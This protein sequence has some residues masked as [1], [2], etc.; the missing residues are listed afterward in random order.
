MNMFNSKEIKGVFLIIFVLAMFMILALLRNINITNP[1]RFIDESEIEMNQ[2]DS[3]FP[4][5]KNTFTNHQNYD[6]KYEVQDEVTDLQF[7]PFDPNNIDKQSLKEMGINDNGINNWLKYLAKGGRFKTKEDVAKIY[8]IS[9]QTFEAMK[10]YLIIEN[11]VN[12]D[13]PLPKAQISEKT[14][15]PDSLSTT[16]NNTTV[17]PTKMVDI[18]FASAEEIATLNGI[19]AILSQRIVKFRDKLGG[20]VRKDQLSEVYGLS[21]ET[22]SKIENQIIVDPKMIH[23]IKINLSDVE[24]LISFPYISKRYANQIVNYRNQHGP[25]KNADDLAKIRSFDESQIEKII[26]Y[27]DFEAR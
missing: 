24:T 22:Y 2:M 16:K 6:P 4:N 9:T 12:S 20:F 18:N 3:I 26:P 11:K 17:K 14:I 21:P 8:G 13:I 25:F 23:K 1:K 5:V 19:G 15:S 7:H 10:D 27:L